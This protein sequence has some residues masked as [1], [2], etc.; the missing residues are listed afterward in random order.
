MKIETLG[1]KTL[2]FPPPPQWFPETEEV[3]EGWVKRERKDDFCV[4]L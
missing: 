2:P 1:G 3:K 4:R